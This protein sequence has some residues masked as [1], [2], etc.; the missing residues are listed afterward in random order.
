MSVLLLWVEKNQVNS[1]FRKESEKV[2]DD[3][4][5]MKPT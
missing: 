1:K 5:I 2:H 4:I 3:I